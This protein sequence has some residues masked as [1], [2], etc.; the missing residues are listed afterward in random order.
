MTSYA[1]EVVIE[2]LTTFRE[3]SVRL[4]YG[5]LV[6]R[7]MIDVK[8]VDG[9]VN[10]SG[11]I[12]YVDSNE[13]CT[14]DIPLWFRAGCLYKVK[15]VGLKRSERSDKRSNNIDSF[16]NISE[17]SQEFKAGTTEAYKQMTNSMLLV[18]IACNLAH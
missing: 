3:A 12:F 7:W 17:A 11:W 8:V 18:L 14:F 9:N 2:R 4:P 10:R 6:D 16:L 1:S 15:V 5:R 13:H